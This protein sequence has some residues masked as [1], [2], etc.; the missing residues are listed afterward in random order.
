M[1]VEEN[2]QPLSVHLK[3]LRRVVFISLLAVFV[4]AM[5]CFGFV[6]EPIMNFITEPIAA[7]S[8][9]LKF[10]SVAEAFMA[11]MKVSILAG[12]IIASP[13]V[14]WQLL[15]F[16][17]PGLYKNEKRMFIGILFW[18][19][20]LFVAGIC[21]AYFAVLKVALNA[22]LFSFSGGFDAFITVGNYLDFVWKFLLPFGIVFEIPI[23]MYFLTK[24][25]LV[26][27]NQLIKYRRYM[28]LII[29]IVAGIFSPPDVI[30]QLLLAL[31][32][33]VLY[34]ISIFIS[35]RVYRKVQKKKAEN[36]I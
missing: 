4:S 25:E 30:S 15:S 19:I 3:A 21:F 16:I 28:I 31:P 26:T 7:Y 17:L 9:D 12:I 29:V 13:V 1:S 33:Y 32:M 5:L 22:L 14:L 36:G 35:K 8:I 20:V 2:K 34:E 10:T 27:P 24:L 11:Y 6:R 18:L 23:L